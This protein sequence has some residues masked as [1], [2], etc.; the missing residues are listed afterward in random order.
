MS[1]VGG[2]IGWDLCGG[3]GVNGY[4]PNL[5]VSGQVVSFMN[6]H[7]GNL[8]PSLAIMEKIGTA[9]CAAVDR[10]AVDNHIPGDAVFQG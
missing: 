9:F 10:V 1:E 6:A 8:I 5:L 3:A 4:V 7:L 2:R